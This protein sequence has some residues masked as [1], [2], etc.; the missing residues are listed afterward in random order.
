MLKIEEEKQLREQSS[1]VY[2]AKLNQMMNVVCGNED[3]CLIIAWNFMVLKT[4]QTQ[5]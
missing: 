1:H 3:G 5:R 4:I 2:Q